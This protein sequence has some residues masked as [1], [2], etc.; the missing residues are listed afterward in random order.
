MDA[1]G[2]LDPTAGGLSQAP[3]PATSP[4]RADGEAPLGYV[5]LLHRDRGPSMSHL[6]ARG[7]SY[8]AMAEWW[9]CVISNEVPPWRQA[10]SWA[11]LAPNAVPRSRSI[12]ASSSSLNAGAMSS[13]AKA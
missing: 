6:K 1:S 8:R 2:R 11:V 4:A 3:E 12:I 7:L 9:A 5:T 10:R 13:R